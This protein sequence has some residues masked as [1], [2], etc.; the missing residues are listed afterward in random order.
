[1]LNEKSLAWGKSK[2]CIRELAAYGAARKQEI[3]EDK[4][5]DFSLGNPS[6]PAPAC[7]EEAL[8]ELVKTVPAAKLHGYTPAA[9]LPSLRAAVAKD[10]NKRW[11]TA[12]EGEH[13]YVCCGA[14]AGLASCMKGLLNSG[15]QAVAFAP[16][17]PEYRV[18]AEGAGAELVVVPPMEDMQPDLES[19]KKAVN[20]KTG[21]VIINSPNNPSGVVLSAENLKALAEILKEAQE[22]Y[23][24]PIYLVSDEPYREL[25]Y[26]DVKLPCVF[27]YYNNSIVVYSFSKSMSLPGERIGYVAVNPK[28]EQG[29]LVFAAVAGAARSYGYVNPPSMM[30]MV[31]ERCLGQTADISLYK[32]NRDL[33]CDILESLNF[34]CVKPDGAFYL[35]VKCPIADAKLFSESAKKYELLLV[36]GDDFGLE[37]YVRLAYCVAEQTIKNSLPAFEKLAKEYGLK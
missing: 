22:K 36:P 26:D 7:V 4:V 35:F 10:L 8:L 5:F 18:F 29:D 13:I 30:Q 11:G 28:M 2:S 9:G 20:E 32:K 12:L 14:A 25:V 27:D 6:I 37:G 23:A 16:F 24:H 1:M 3:G 19:F 33:L 15:E 17:F 21:I 31:V 34:K